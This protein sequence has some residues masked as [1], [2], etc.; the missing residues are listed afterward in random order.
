MV[1]KHTGEAVYIHFHASPEGLGTLVVPCVNN[2]ASHMLSL[3]GGLVIV[4]GFLD[5]DSQ[6]GFGSVL[7]SGGHHGV[8][9]L[10][11]SRQ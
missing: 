4:G 9:M 2:A 6:L 5:V 7:V 11:Q 10:R 8:D 1:S 3:R